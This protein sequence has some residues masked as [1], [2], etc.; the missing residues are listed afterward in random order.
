MKKVINP[1]TGQ[2]DHVM[3]RD[4]VA[5]YLE[6][7]KGQLNFRWSENCRLNECFIPPRRVLHGI[8]K[9]FLS[10]IKTF[11]EQNAKFILKPKAV[12]EK[13][14]ENNKNNNIIN[15]PQK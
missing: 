6:M 13:N 9:A 12:V 4:E 14:T 10:E 5:E 8:P 1:F 11:K 3:N 7:T 15:Y 2:P